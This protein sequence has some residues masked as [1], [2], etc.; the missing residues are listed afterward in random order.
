MLGDR[1]VLVGD[2]GAFL[3]P[4]FSTGVL[5]A[6]ESALEAA[7]VLSEGLRP[8]DLS[9]R[10]LRAVRAPP[11]AALPALPPL[12]GRVLRAG[13]PRLFLRRDR[14]GLYQCGALDPRRQLASFARTRLRIA[15]CS[16][17]WSGCNVEWRSSSG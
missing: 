12:R 7:G 13:V 11:C 6:M 17:R 10:P 1:Y 8:G 14:F 3:D 15:L 2:A 4:I 9:R 16:S 5:L